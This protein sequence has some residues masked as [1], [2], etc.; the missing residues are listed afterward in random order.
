MGELVPR[1]YYSPV[2]VTRATAKQLARIQQESLISRAA[3]A[4]HERDA[5]YQAACR[6]DNV[7]N[8]STQAVLRAEALDHVIRQSSRGNLHL[9]AIQRGFEETAALGARI[10]IHQLMTR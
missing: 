6:I 8:R 2:P 1:D 9:E 4:A 10:I 5:D 7:Y 3:I